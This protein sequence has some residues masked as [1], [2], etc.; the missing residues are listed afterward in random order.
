MPSRSPGF[1]SPTWEFWVPVP[2]PSA[3]TYRTIVT[4]SA[5][6]EVL[7]SL[8]DQGDTHLQP[9]STASFDK[10]CP[11]LGDILSDLSHECVEGWIRP[12]IA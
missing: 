6:P 3:H 12:L 5:R 4:L 8:V 9:S 10:Y 11:R 1:S 7:D 2:P